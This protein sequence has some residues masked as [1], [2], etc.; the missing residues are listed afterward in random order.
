MKAYDISTCEIPSSMLKFYNISEAIWEQIFQG[1]F[2]IVS[3]ENDYLPSNGKQLMI[4]LNFF[5]KFLTNSKFFDSESKFVKYGSSDVYLYSLFENRY[6]N[7]HDVISMITNN[8]VDKF[9]SFFLE[10]KNFQMEYD[11]YSLIDCVVLSENID[12][13]RFLILN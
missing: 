5:R 10:K 6:H 11:F 7:G 9:K 4:T 13:F 12:I 1:N 3:H 2:N 8:D